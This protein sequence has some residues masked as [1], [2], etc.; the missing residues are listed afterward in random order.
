MQ[1]ARIELLQRMPIFGGIHTDTLQFLL[2]FC[3]I[4][5]VAA[6]DFFFRELEDGDSMFVLEQGKCAVLKSWQKEDFLLQTL[7]EGDCFGEM[8]LID[9]CPR[10]ASVRAVEECRA[11]RISAADLHRVYARDLKQFALIQMNMG[12]EVCRRLREANG[13]LFSAKMG[14]PDTDGHLFLAA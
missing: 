7:G 8:A 13:R 6:K 11:I 14:V 9:H 12:R 4:V 2:A 1:D 3:P 10:S 5:S